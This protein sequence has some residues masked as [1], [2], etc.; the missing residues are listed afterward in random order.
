MEL[1]SVLY[2]MAVRSAVLMLSALGDIFNNNC[3]ILHIYWQRTC[4]R[5]DRK[6]AEPD[7]NEPEVVY[8]DPGAN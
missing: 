5:S 2:L 7:P 6:Y 3:K 1:I 8:V 4:N